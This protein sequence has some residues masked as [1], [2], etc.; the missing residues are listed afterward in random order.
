MKCPYCFG[1]GY[2][3]PYC[4]GTGEAKRPEDESWNKSDLKPSWMKQSGNLYGSENLLKPKRQKEVL[5]K[6]A[7][8][9]GLKRLNKYLPVSGFRKKSKSPKILISCNSCGHKIPIT[10]EILK[11]LSKRLSINI[12]VL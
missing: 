11:N 3:C 6:P 5:Y 2:L 10:N 7:K 12:S 1:D 8:V 9:K 4:Y